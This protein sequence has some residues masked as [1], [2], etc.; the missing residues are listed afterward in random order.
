VQFNPSLPISLFCEWLDWIFGSSVVSV[1]S[2][3]FSSMQVMK[4]LQKTGVENIDTVTLMA[5]CNNPSYNS[6]YAF[7]DLGRIEMH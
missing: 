1:L 3:P 5:D 6:G 4:L 7:I 2:S